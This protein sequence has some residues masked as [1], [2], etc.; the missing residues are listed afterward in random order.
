MKR[1]GLEINVEQRFKDA[2]VDALFNK[3]LDGALAGAR[4]Q[5]SNFD[6]L[7]FNARLVV[8]DMMFM[9]E[10]AFASSRR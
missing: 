8:V 5:V 10:A 7:A 2:Q 9:G 4:H 3:D 1:I 6:S